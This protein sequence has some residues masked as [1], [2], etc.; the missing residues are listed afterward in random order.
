MIIEK[1]L[2]KCYSNKILHYSMTT[3]NLNY[4]YLIGSN[5][6]VFLSFK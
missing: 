5:D 3:F 2:E 4:Q 1:K 6:L